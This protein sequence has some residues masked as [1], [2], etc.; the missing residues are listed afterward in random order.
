MVQVLPQ[1][2]WVYPGEKP[3]RLTEQGRKDLSNA[4][5]EKGMALIESCIGTAPR[6]VVPGNPCC[7]S[8]LRTGVPFSSELDRQRSAVGELGQLHVIER[9][10]PLDE[11]K[12]SD[13]SLPA[14]ARP[15]AETTAP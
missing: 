10:A 12:S 4:V 15:Q 9:I 5:G 3:I 2:S 1:S 14:P 13:R 7:F 6:Y 8:F 11:W